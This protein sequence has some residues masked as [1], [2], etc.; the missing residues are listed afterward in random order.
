MLRLGY[1]NIGITY[2]LIGGLVGS[3]ILGALAYLMP[4]PVSGSNTSLVP[5]FASV[6]VSLHV[7]L[8]ISVPVGW[9]MNL[10]AG[11]LMGGIF[12]AATSFV[13]GL[14]LES[15]PKGIGLGII[16]GVAAYALFFFPIFSLIVPQLYDSI[17]SQITETLGAHIVFG[18]VM[19]G[20]AAAG[21]TTNH[22]ARELARR[23]REDDRVV[24]TPLAAAP[25]Q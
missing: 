25:R 3:I 19:G 9:V 24:A 16:A 4:V 18:I 6:A 2:G 14:K 10:V 23:I 17:N 5:F 8:S 22:K 15:I 11:L 13:P 1:G 20:I 12:G 21:M 7:P